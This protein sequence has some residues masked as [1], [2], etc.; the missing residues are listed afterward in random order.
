MLDKFS[1]NFFAQ[2]IW[3]KTYEF[4][5]QSKSNISEQTPLHAVMLYFK[6]RTIH[7]LAQL[8][9]NSSEANKQ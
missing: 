7:M 4:S 6:L 8:Q 5:K 2:R 1:E 9:N 3:K